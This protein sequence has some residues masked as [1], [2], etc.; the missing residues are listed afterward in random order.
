[1]TE[2]TWQVLAQLGALGPIIWLLYRMLPVLKEVAVAFTRLEVR[3]DTHCAEQAEAIRQHEQRAAQSWA[4]QSR[5]NDVIL[6]KL[7]GAKGEPQQGS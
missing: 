2:P 4:E 6:R 5:W 7:N 1:M 3:I